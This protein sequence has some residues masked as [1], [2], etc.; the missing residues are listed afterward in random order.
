MSVTPELAGVMSAITTPLTRDGRLDV[1]LLVRQTLYLREAG[2]DGYFVGG[3]T[4][5][6][7]FL[8][9]ETK[10]TACR[11]IRQTAKPEQFIALAAL[12]ASTTQVLAEME[13]LAPLEPEFFVA[14]TPYYGVT[15]QS[16][17]VSHFRVLAENS[18]APLALYNIPSRT[19]SPMT[20]ETIQ[21]LAALDNVVGMKDSSGDFSLFCRGVLGTSADLPTGGV[22]PGHATDVARPPRKP[23]SWIMG[24]DS[25]QAPALLVGG[26]GMVSGLSNIRAEAHV[27]MY[28]A[29][30]EGDLQRVL[31]CQR[32][33]NDLFR[34]IAACEGNVNGAVKAGAAYYG[35]CS[36]WMVMSSMT[37]KED[38]ITAVAAVLEE[39]EPRFSA[40]LRG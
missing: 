22:P 34:V 9:L 25:L 4:A 13:A 27:A 24:E 5:E 17:I 21:E 40:I 1:D 30:R 31:A 7:A 8:D 3:T 12:A 32:L 29:N 37:A 39:L 35:R 15:R 16:D 20:L 10:K 14:V 38:Q 2:V 36:P 19:Q 23:F 26:D 28:R 6:G 11:V 33:V 18:P